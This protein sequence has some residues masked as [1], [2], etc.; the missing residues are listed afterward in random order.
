M[1]RVF[2]LFLEAMEVEDGATGGE[3]NS[4]GSSSK[5]WNHLRKILERPSPFA[6]HTFNPGF[7]YITALQEYVRVL[8]V[9]AGG[10]GCELLKNLVLL[11]FRNVDIIDMDTIDISNLN[12]QFLFR[13]DDVGK[14]KAQC[15]AAFVNKRVE[16]ANVVA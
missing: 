4:S 2:F 9:G 11:G 1:S 16:G 13:P 5:R 8:V 7:D 3:S 14:S 6:Y 15:A 12:R 10:L